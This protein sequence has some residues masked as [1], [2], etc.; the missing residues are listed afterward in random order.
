MPKK[1]HLNEL[2]ICLYHLSTIQKIKRVIYLLFWILFHLKIRDIFSIQ[3][4][5]QIVNK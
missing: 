3:I 1:S 4:I 2:I 5:D